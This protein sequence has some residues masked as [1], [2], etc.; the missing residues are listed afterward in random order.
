M[1]EVPKE[2]SFVAHNTRKPDNLAST[3]TLTSKPG[4][5]ALTTKASTGSV[6]DDLFGFGSATATN[7]INQSEQASA[8]ATTTASL[9]PFAIPVSGNP[10]PS[11][12]TANNNELTL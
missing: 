3:L 1:H 4:G 8:G 2:L 12:S 6:L 9:D 11:T 5:N 10:A 7:T